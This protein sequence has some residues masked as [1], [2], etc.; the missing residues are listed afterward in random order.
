MPK[1]PE[2]ATHLSRADD[3]QIVSELPHLQ[4]K[5]MREMEMVLRSYWQ[6]LARTAN[7]QERFKDPP[8][9]FF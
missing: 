8:P 5:K 9:E 2:Q 4:S 6:I 3:L 7:G 1:P